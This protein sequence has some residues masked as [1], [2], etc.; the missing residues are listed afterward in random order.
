MNAQFQY[1]T[2]FYEY[3]VGES[4]FIEFNN[5][6]TLLFH[7]Q[8][9]PKIWPIQFTNDWLS[10]LRHH[11]FD[12]QRLISFVTS[13]TPKYQRISTFPKSQY[14]RLHSR[15]SSIPTTF[16]RP[17]PWSQNHR[18]GVSTPAWV[19]RRILHRKIRT[20]SWDIPPCRISTTNHSH[21]RCTLLLHHHHHRH[22]IHLHPILIHILQRRIHIQIPIPSPTTTTTTTTSS[23]SSPSPPSFTIPT[24]AAPRLGGC[25]WYW[26]WV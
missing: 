20:P 10:L 6:V 1:C 11:G 18:E 24:A 22:A 26:Y 2:S 3:N 7:L 19:T 9:L 25:C 13:P 4:N 21:S 17:S 16:R 23:S 8:F 5:N 14:Q 15:P 12:V